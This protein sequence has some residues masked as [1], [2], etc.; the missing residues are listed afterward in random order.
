MLVVA[1][2]LSKVLLTT[3]KDSV[4]AN[5]LAEKVDAGEQQASFYSV[6]FLVPKKDGGLRPILD[7]RCMKA[8]EGLVLQ[9]A[10]DKA[11]SGV[12]RVQEFHIG[13]IHS[14]LLKF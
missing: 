2:A 10:P 8:H 7:L 4:Q 12:H 5:I 1:S 11:H 3:V 9:N 14:S 6:Y 13:R